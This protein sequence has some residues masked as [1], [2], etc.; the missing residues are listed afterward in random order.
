MSQADVVATYGRKP[1][2]DQA[3]RWAYTE[4]VFESGGHYSTDFVVHFDRNG[5]VSRTECTPRHYDW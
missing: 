5:R 4:H 2:Q 3:N 1:D